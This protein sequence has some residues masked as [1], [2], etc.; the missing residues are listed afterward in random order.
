MS[1]HPNDRGTPRGDK[2]DAAAEMVS[3]DLQN[4]Q[5]DHTRV[6]PETTSEPTTAKTSPRMASFTVIA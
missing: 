6:Q 5:L 4:G 3:R 1:R 2:F